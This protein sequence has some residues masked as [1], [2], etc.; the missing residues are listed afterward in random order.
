MRRILP[1]TLAA[2]AA[3]AVLPAA[4]HA[5]TVSMND[6]VLTYQA[7]PGEKNRPAIRTSGAAYIVRDVTPGLTFTAGPGCVKLNATEIRCSRTSEP[8]FPTMIKVFLGDGNDGVNVDVAGVYTDI[9]GQDGDDIFYGGRA[10]GESRIEFRGHA[11]TDTA[12]Y[13]TS[14]ARVN[15]SK[16]ER[17]F[18][19]RAGDHENIR[20]DVERLVG[21]PYNDMLQGFDNAFADG[22]PNEQFVGGLGDDYMR[23]NGGIDSFDMGAVNDGPD[24]V[25]GG[26][27]TDHVDYGSRTHSVRVTIDHGPDQDDGATGE[28]DFVEDVEQV[29]GGTAGDHIAAEPGTT[30]SVWFLGMGG[31]DTLLGSEGADNLYGEG[32][33]SAENAGS[34]NIVGRGGDD[35]IAAHDG[36]KDT[37]NC[38]A[39]EDSVYR[40]AVEFQVLSC[41]SQRIF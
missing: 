2:V 25:D 29:E 26:A 39:G 31:A 3:A 22:W 20:R 30:E 10:N 27:G 36:V 6:P 13:E 38:G 15:V 4:A 5:A 7:A 32:L 41:E 21:S 23:G 24:R 17:A 34:D 35:S 9:W 40:N 19:G 12:S 14:D 28:R 8:Q 37:I 33:G 1:I 11:G 16:D 18:D